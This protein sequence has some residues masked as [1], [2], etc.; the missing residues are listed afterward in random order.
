MI[1]VELFLQLETRVQ[2]QQQQQH[3]STDHSSFNELQQLARCRGYLD[4][5]FCL[6]IVVFIKQCNYI[7]CTY[8]AYY[9]W[10]T[11]DMTVNEKQKPLLFLQ[12][13]FFINKKYFDYLFRWLT[14]QLFFCRPT[15]VSL[16]QQVH[17]R[18]KVNSLFPLEKFKLIY[19]NNFNST[20]YCAF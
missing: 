13:I 17:N 12:I 8:S 15:M 10:K 20:H 2:Q 9:H 14:N 16:Q 19:R 6:Y 3:I 5:G 18:Q 1:H 7:L 11:T 4:Y